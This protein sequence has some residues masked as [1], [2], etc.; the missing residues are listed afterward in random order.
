[1]TA[2]L[3]FDIGANNGDVTAFYLAKGFRVVAVEADP[4]LCTGLEARFAVEVASGDLIIENVGVAGS[5][6]TLDFYVNSYSEWNSFVK[7]V[8]RKAQGVTRGWHD[9]HCRLAAV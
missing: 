1:M 8:A 6:G 7:G 2:R 4:S 9:I 5:D 3:I